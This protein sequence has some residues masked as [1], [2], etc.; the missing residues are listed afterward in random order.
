VARAP[1]DVAV[2]VVVRDLSGGPAGLGVLIDRSRVVTCAH[3]VERA[4]GRDTGAARSTDGAGNPDAAG[5]IA[6]QVR[7]QLLRRERDGGDRCLLDVLAV[8]SDWDPPASADLAVLT[9]PPPAPG[10][11]PAAALPAGEVPAAAVPVARLSACGL[12]VGRWPQPLRVFGYPAGR[13]RGQWT[14]VRAVGVVDGGRVQLNTVD[15]ALPSVRAGYSGSP[16]LDPL[17]GDVVAL[18]TEAPAS[19]GSHESLAI[20]ASVVRAFL[21]SSSGGPPLTV[22]VSGSPAAGGHGAP[23]ASATPTAPATSATSATPST[24]TA[25]AT[26][27]TS[28]APA[29][30]A[31][32]RPERGYA[33][34]DE[35]TVLHLSDLHFGSGHG[36]GAE[37]L[38]AADRSR[39]TLAARLRDDLDKLADTRG[40]WPDLVVVTGDLT[41]RA[42]PAEFEQAGTFLAGLLEAVGL[43]RHRLAMVP[44]NHDINRDAAL[45]YCATEGSFGREAKP[46]YA[47]KWRNYQLAFQ[48][49]YAELP[50]DLGATT[51][52]FTPE[53]HPWTLFELPDLKVAVVGQLDDGRE[54]P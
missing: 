13:P 17:S 19:G 50:V 2:V 39:D 46:P 26:S 27:A 14:E 24:P 5:G 36:F 1:E 3:V 40:L 20:P 16:V 23:A 34:A 15:R 32:R 29:A 21:T 33:P 25:S 4:L 7:V 45:A 47:P 48:G 6:R 41:Q 18:V 35:L 42:L 52:L 30:P 53:R 38:T 31:R 44:G 10:M 49:F 51:P 8:V 54:P 28:A 9:L 11:V 43:P 37:G 22:G 12:D